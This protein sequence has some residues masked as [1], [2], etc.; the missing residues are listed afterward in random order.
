MA[1][2]FGGLML[3]SNGSIWNNHFTEVE[4]LIGKAQIRLG[5]FFIKHNLQ[6]EIAVSPMDLTLNR[7][8][9][10]LMMNGGWDQRA[11]GKAYNSSSGRLVSVGSR[12]N[13]VCGLAYY[14]KR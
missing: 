14:S 5:N 7:A 11:S 12:T 6:N 3:L 13:T 9:V 4:I 1:S 8:K 10:T 2:T